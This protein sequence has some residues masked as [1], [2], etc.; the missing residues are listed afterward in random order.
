VVGTRVCDHTSVFAVSA[1]VPMWSYLCVRSECP[2][3]RVC[4]T[5]VFAVSARVPMRSYLCVRRECLCTRVCHTSVFAV[6][7]RIPVWSY[8]CVRNDGPCTRANID[9]G[10]CPVCCDMCR[11]GCTCWD[12][13]TRPHLELHF[14]HW[15]L[16]ADTKHQNSTSMKTC[17]RIRSMWIF[18]FQF[19]YLALNIYQVFSDTIRSVKLNN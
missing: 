7:T 8:L 11:G 9:S 10:S 12:Y 4:H 15:P 14:W 1:R 2:C 6:S 13:D 19:L 3:T 5:S 17:F 16:I 18:Q